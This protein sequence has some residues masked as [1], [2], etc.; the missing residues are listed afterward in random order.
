MTSMNSMNAMP[1]NRVQ[2]NPGGSHQS[3]ATNLN[4]SSIL[5]QLGVHHAARR[6]GVVLQG[7]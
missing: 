3:A 7:C 2:G 1:N 5:S 6:L 4:I